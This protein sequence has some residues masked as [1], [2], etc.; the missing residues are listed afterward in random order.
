LRE[1]QSRLWADMD[2]LATAPP[3]RQKEQMIEELRAKM[4]LNIGSMMDA[5]LQGIEDRL[6]PERRLRP[7]LASDKGPVPAS[8]AVAEPE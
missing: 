7:P 3:Q 1:G 5:K 8:G 4:M 6:L 2:Q